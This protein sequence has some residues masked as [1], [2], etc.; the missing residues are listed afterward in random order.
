MD[1]KWLGLLALTMT[2]TTGCELLGGGSPDVTPGADS[3]ET[4]EDVEPTDPSTDPLT[5]T[6]EEAAALATWG[7]REVTFDLPDGSGATGSELGILLPE[8]ALDEIDVI[9]TLS[10]AQD[11]NSSRSNNSGLV[12]IDD[13]LDGGDDSTDTDEPGLQVYWDG[14][15]CADA[16]CRSG[17]R[18]PGASRRLQLVL[19]DALD[20]DGMTGVRWGE[21]TPSSVSFTGSLALGCK[22]PSCHVTVLKAVDDGAGTIDF[23]SCVEGGAMW[24]LDDRSETPLHEASTTCGTS[25][26]ASVRGTEGANW[27]SGVRVSETP[28]GL[29]VSFLW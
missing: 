22:V 14:V 20:D 18:A 27:P 28:V 29:L 26:L 12:E 5:L 7:P 15:R 11:Y 13:D 19:G 10:R 6:D 8:V 3:C 25:P 9:S 17:G 16:S 1:A 4:G 23:Y 21:T 24:L 2:V